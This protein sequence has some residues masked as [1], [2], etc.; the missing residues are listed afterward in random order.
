MGKTVNR[1]KNSYVYEIII[2]SVWRSRRN[3]E[4]AIVNVI[5]PIISRN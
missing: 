5:L 1:E 2:Y 4:K 3:G